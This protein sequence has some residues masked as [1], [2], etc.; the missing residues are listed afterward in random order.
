MLFPAALVMALWFPVPAR[1]LTRLPWLPWGAYGLAGVL[2]LAYQVVLRDPQ[3]YVVSHLLS[4]SAFGIA[5]VALVVA[6]VERFRR[7]MSLLARER[8]RITAIGA[9]LALAVPIAFSAAE[10]LTGGRS[11]QNALA[12]TGVIFP[13]ALA[14][15]LSRGGYEAIKPV[16]V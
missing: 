10:L 9:L 15:A 5:L 11:P 7:P 16:R 4:V 3:A 2:A 12:F 13:L 6:E 8:L 14:Y 1:M